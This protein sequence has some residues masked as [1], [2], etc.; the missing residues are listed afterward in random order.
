MWL[1]CIFRDIVFYWLSS[2][3]AE[4]KLLK[5]GSINL[6]LSHFQIFSK[7]LHLSNKC[8]DDKA[9]IYCNKIKIIDYKEYLSD[10][11]P[12]FHGLERNIQT[13]TCF[14]KMSWKWFQESNYW[15]PMNT[16][17]SYC[18]VSKS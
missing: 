1:Q 16:K 15:L 12:C 13:K 14:T 17:L 4:I 6:Q 5:I 3:S 10:S 11:I 7:I 18:N 8:D 9:N 2:C